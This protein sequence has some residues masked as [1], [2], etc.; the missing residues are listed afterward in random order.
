MIFQILA[1]SLVGTSLGLVEQSATTDQRSLSSLAA[2]YSYQIEYTTDGIGETPIA[3]FSLFDHEGR[4]L[5]TLRRPGVEMIF[6]SDQGWFVGALNHA[7]EVRLTFYSRNGSIRAQT[8][9]GSPAN[10]AFSAAGSYFYVNNA[11]GVQAF[12]RDGQMTARFGT[13]DW[14]RPSADDQLLALVSGKRITVQSFGAS[15][16]LATFDLGSQLFRDLAFSP[17]GKYVA[18]AGQREISLYSL[19]ARSEVWRREFEPAAALLTL[20]VDDNGRVYAGGQI[21]HAG[22]LSVLADG[23]E[24][25]R[26]AIPYADDRETINRI[27]LESDGVHVTTA[28]HEFRFEEAK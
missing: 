8:R 3:S 21:E 26:A 18:V 14:F 19:R 24:L 13:A 17:G 4:P 10:Y 25:T 15:S 27:S 7:N 16:P 12:D 1:L 9:T 20:A 11:R 28:D 6:V 5:T 23:E 22:F 2:H